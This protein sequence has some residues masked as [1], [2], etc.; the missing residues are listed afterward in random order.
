MN[1]DNEQISYDWVVQFN[2]LNVGQQDFLGI[3]YAKTNAGDLEKFW[4]VWRKNGGD[5]R[6]SLGGEN[7][8]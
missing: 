5:L 3:L 7:K 1:S 2:F 6:D 8:L 4:V